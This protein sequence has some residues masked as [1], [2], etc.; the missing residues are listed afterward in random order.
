VTA[1]TSAAE[2]PFAL[3]DSVLVIT[4]VAGWRT[5]QIRQC[6]LSDRQART[7]TSCRCTWPHVIHGSSCP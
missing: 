6:Q 2:D 3:A 5:P 7:T 4:V 1:F